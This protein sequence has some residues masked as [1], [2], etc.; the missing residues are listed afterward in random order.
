MQINSKYDLDAVV[1]TP[2]EDKKKETVLP[3][4]GKVF[5]V[6]LN[7]LGNIGY[8]IKLDFNGRWEPY[9]TRCE[10]DIFTD[11]QACQ[12][13]CVLINEDLA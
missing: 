1:W 6:S 10:T 7:S 11:I 2:W 12:A 8:L 4:K 9:E 5:A 3:R 13:E